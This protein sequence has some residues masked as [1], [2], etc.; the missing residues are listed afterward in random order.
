VLWD[1]E[2]FRPD[3]AK[4][5][6]LHKKNSQ[7][8]PHADRR[9]RHA[10]RALGH[11]G[12]AALDLAGKVLWKQVVEY[13]PAHGNGGSPALVGDLLVFNCD[14]VADPFV[15]ALDAKTGETRWK[16]PRNTP[17]RQQFSVATPIAIDVGGGGTQIVS[18]GSGFVG[19]YD[20][21]DGREILARPLRRGLLGHHPPGLRR[22]RRRAQLRV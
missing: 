7:A 2:V 6:T 15:I 16:T 14:G 11:L 9:R 12:T 5:Q 8:S 10:L 20:P 22:R 1:T 21:K 19:G 18:P 3:P 17:A 13:R 4:T